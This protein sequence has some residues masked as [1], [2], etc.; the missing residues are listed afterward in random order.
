[1]ATSQQNSH[2]IESRAVA[3]LSA[4]LRHVRDA[5]HLGGDCQ[6]GTSLDQAYHL[7]ALGPECVRKA[8]LGTREFDKLIGHGLE[9]HILEVALAL[10]PLAHR[11]DPKNWAQRYP[12]LA[13]WKLDCRYK[14][15]GTYDVGAV[16]QLL[17]EARQ[18]VDEVVLALWADGRLPRDDM[19][20]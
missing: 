11:Y 18:A 19:P 7:A 12:A 20:W 1:M 15:T 4:A 5:H 17:A 2:V 8:I 13:A 3:L 10:D 14:R 9:D 6:E 16:R